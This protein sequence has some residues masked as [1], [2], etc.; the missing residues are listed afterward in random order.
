MKTLIVGTGVIG[1][2][3]GWA[4]AEAGVDVTHYVRPG[5][6]VG[7]ILEVKLD[8]LDER[9]GHK[10]NNL[11]SY[12]MRCVDSVKPEDQYELFILPVNANQLKDVLEVLV[13]CSGEAIFL[14]LT[15]NWDGTA[16]LDA[17]LPRERYLLG[18]ADGGGTIRDSVYW[19]NLGAEIH[20]GEADGNTSQKLLRVKAL[21]EKADMK[22]DLQPNM[23][24]WLWVHNASATGFAAGFAKHKAIQP[25]LKD[26]D[27]LKTSVEATRELLTLCERRGVNL[28]E[29]PEIS[30]LSW[31]NWL[32]LA[33]MRW[34]YTTNKSMQRFTAHAAS[35]GSLRE[36]KLNYDAMLKTADELGVATP[37]MLAL[38]KYLEAIHP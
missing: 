25:F 18:Y 35:A 26:G 11:T 9:K 14:T 31:P 36:T 5:K 24:Y 16:T 10:P 13:P 34:L 15:S 38:G 33:V 28:K 20:L 21:F 3:Y 6:K 22:P 2:I 37:A 23:L 19:T 27:L 1:T 8:V 30:F 29:Y 7:D 17:L 32:V 12:T 4:L